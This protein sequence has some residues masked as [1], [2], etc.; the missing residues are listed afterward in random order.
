ME[1]TIKTKITREILENIFITALEGGSN[2]WYWLESDDIEKA[3]GIC[4]N[5]QSTSE[6]LFEAIYDHGM[7]LPIY[8]IESIEDGP[9]GELDRDTFQERLQK[10]YNE[11]P[12]H[13]QSELSENGDAE[14]SDVIFQYLALD[15]LIY[16]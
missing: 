7:V 1:I 15:E 12:L 4:I 10:C 2:Y 3:R 14:S 8:D 16:G 6:A 11:M 9:I 13:L 5:S